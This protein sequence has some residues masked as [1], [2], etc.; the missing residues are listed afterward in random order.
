MPENPTPETFRAYATGWW[1]PEGGA[2][3]TLERMEFVSKDDGFYLRDI[4][5]LSFIIFLVA[6]SAEGVLQLRM[7]WRGKRYELTGQT[8]GE[9]TMWGRWTGA[10][11]TGEWF[12][13]LRPLEMDAGIQTLQVVTAEGIQEAIRLL[14]TPKQE[15]R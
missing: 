15:T 7:Y 13:A 6:R 9:G 3:E 5:P 11:G 2:R 8:D 4:K 12:I 1:Q 14:N 10:A